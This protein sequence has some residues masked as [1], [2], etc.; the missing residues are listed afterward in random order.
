MRRALIFLLFLISAPSFAYTINLAYEESLEN[1]K[2]NETERFFYCKNKAGDQYLIKSDGWG[3]LAFKRTKDGKYEQKAVNEVYDSS[4]NDIFI[5]PFN[6]G[7]YGMAQM[8]LPYGGTLAEFSQG[9]GM[10][11]RTFFGFET[12]ED[13]VEKSDKEIFDFINGVKAEHESRR[14]HFSSA[15]N[16]SQMK[17]EL[18][19]GSSLNCQRDPTNHNCS[20]LNCG[21]DKK[22][23]DVLLFKDRFADN[24]YFE[25]YSFKKFELAQDFSRV[26]RIF[27]ANGEE[28][29]VKQET[30]PMD[31]DSK[32]Y[33]TQ[34]LV[35]SEHRNNPELFFSAMDPMFTSSMLHEFN[36]CSPNL[37][38]VLEKALKKMHDDRINADMVQMIDYA[39]GVLD[40]NFVNIETL[41]DFACVHNG[42]YY[43]PEGYQHAKKVQGQMSKKTITMKEAQD[44]HDRA[45]A[46]DDIAWEYTYDGCYARA[47]LMARMFEAEGVHVNKAWLRGEL[48]IPGEA[49]DKNWGYHVAPMVYVEDGK[50]G[51]KEMIID[52]SISDKPIPPKDWAALMEVD[53]GVTKQVAYPT[54]N[55]TAFF[56]DTSYAV[57]TSEPYWPVQ[58]TRLTEEAKMSM[59]RNRMEEYIHGIDPW[60]SSWQEF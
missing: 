44:L 17:V 20:V 34:S 5:A 56:E 42:V 30:Y 50:G 16:S 46:R 59:A 35:P 23:N 10:V 36:E 25:S 37:K 12:E 4:G 43:T 7:G 52:P 26:K 57:T 58:D 51:V 6:R 48:Q 33:K 1:C 60:G 8:D 54:P 49:D 11:H 14:K 27:A 32:V 2:A 29:I 9:L 22:G 15:M 39:N 41:P 47:H 55:N 28:I 45:R 38:K 40:S 18:E 3:Y 21:K 31:T 19:D 53:Y 24:P 13:K